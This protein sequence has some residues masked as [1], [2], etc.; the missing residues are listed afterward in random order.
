MTDPDFKLKI[1]T[2]NENLIRLNALYESLNQKDIQKITKETVRKA[3]EVTTK[4]SELTA[5]L[6]K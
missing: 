6:V 4:T 1:K 2:F 3:K 5:M